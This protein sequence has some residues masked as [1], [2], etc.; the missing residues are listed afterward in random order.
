MDF[1]WTTY[2]GNV[3]WLRERTIFLTR[4]GSHAYGTS[5]PTSDLDLRGVC[6]A[7]R[8]YQLGFLHTV[9]IVEQKVPDL[10]VF[11][12][13]ELF[14]QAVDGAAPV[15]EMLFTDPR[16]HLVRTAAV[17]PL[18]AA[19]QQFLSTKLRH[20]FRGF[21]FANLKRMQ[22]AHARGED[23]SG[24]RGHGKRACHVV[25]L[26]R[27]C[28][29]ILTTGEVIVRRPDAEE[30]LA[31]RAGAWS[32]EEVCAWAE[33]EDAELAELPT[34]LPREVDRTALDALCVSM[35]EASL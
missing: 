31:I 6:V 22:I 30:L 12:L 17:E 13:R 18:L 27:M 7:P 28:R 9:R 1:D 11:E 34:T 3:A 33:R 10:A 5:T 25:R 21:A 20:T 24:D 19:R 26:L 15:I 8:S 14:R 29:E 2:T 32:Y 35:I 16:D 4:H 23:A